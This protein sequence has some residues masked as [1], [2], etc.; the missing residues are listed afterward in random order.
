M[1]KGIERSILVQQYVNT[2]ASLKLSPESS[3]GLG[4]SCSELRDIKKKKL[5]ESIEPPRITEDS[6]HLSANT[7]KDYEKLIFGIKSHSTAQLYDSFSSILLSIPFIRF[8]CVV[9]GSLLV[10]G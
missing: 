9:N 1:I 10:L 2:V 5:L 6:T 3:S 8:S 7:K 4:Q